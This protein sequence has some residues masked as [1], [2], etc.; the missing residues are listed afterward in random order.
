[1]SLQLEIYLVNDEL[2]IADVFKP[3]LQDWPLVGFKAGR[4]EC[5]VSNWASLFQSR[6]AVYK[7]IWTVLKW[8]ESYIGP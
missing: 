7:T 2:T 8:S 5:S 1:M 6:P 4:G 3:D